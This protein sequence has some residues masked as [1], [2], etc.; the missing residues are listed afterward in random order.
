M[1]RNFAK[2]TIMLQGVHVSEKTPRH[3][4]SVGLLSA[5]T[6]FERRFF[7]WADM[8]VVLIYDT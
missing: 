6:V 1:D 2:T 8:F 7:F 4:T 5:D 3:I